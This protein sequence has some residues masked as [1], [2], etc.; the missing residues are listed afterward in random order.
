MYFSI[1]IIS[2]TTI[3]NFKKHKKMLKK[4]CKISM[5]DFLLHKIKNLYSDVFL[6][7]KNQ[8]TVKSFES[9]YYVENDKL[10]NSKKL[11][12]VTISNGKKWL[13]KVNHYMLIAVLDRLAA[14]LK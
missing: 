1:L 4:T 2:L 6:L 12:M 13:L 14:F 9:K 7:E 10:L 5:S 8:L 3:L 11:L